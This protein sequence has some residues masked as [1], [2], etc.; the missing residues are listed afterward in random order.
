MFNRIITGILF[1]LFYIVWAPCAFIKDMLCVVSIPVDVQRLVNTWASF[2][3]NTKRICSGEI[4]KQTEEKPAE[5]E[6][7]TVGFAPYPDYNP[8]EAGEIYL[9]DDEEIPEEL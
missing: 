6:Q 7:K 8:A 9:D 4:L 5:A 2:I 1:A 3:I